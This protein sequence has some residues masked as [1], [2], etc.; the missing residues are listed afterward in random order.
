MIASGNAVIFP[1]HDLLW[2][3]HCGEKEAP[4]RFGCPEDFRVEFS[5]L[6]RWDKTR[7]AV[8]RNA[9]NI[10]DNGDVLTYALFPFDC[11]AGKRD[12][13]NPWGKR[14]SGSAN[15][16]AELRWAIEAIWDGKP[17]EIW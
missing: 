6:P 7:W 1:E 2:I 8:V 11:R 12:I 9:N 15:E 16:V 17:F 13:F 3:D 4:K 14:V 5:K 10:D